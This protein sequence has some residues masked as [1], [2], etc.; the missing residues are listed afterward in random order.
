LEQ[1][2]VLGGLMSAMDQRVAAVEQSMK[3]QF[4][5]F[6]SRLNSHI[7]SE[8]RQEAQAAKRTAEVQSRLDAVEEAQR[9]SEARIRDLAQ[10]IEQQNGKE[11]N[12]R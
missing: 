9:A 10:R 8:R 6:E 7:R 12:D 4:G 5:A 11:D 1:V 3:D 2:P